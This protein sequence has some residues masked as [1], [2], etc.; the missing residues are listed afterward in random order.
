MF[1]AKILRRDCQE[2]LFDIFGALGRKDM[3]ARRFL[4]N[5]GRGDHADLRCFLQLL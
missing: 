1:I 5:D 3:R 4:D 2:N